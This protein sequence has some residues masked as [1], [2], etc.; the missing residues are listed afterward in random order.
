VAVIAKTLKLFVM[1][2]MS[3][4]LLPLLSRMH[5]TDFFRLRNREKFNLIIWQEVASEIYG[6]SLGYRVEFELPPLAGWF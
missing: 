2:P 5:A 6:T 1:F 3:P 4:Y